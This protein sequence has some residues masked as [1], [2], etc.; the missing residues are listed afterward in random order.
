MAVAIRNARRFVDDQSGAARD[1][2]R[3][4][5]RRTRPI[6]TGASRLA[7]PGALDRL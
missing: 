2:R 7:R 4:A 5:T 1:G 3:F 6:V